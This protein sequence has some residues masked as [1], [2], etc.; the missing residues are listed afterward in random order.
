MQERIEEQK[1]IERDIM[2]RAR[3]EKTNVDQERRGMF[4][5]QAMEKP[6]KNP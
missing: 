5:N 2:D 3:Q 6:I 4:I 1:Q